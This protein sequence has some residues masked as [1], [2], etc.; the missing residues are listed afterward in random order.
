[1]PQWWYVLDANGDIPLDFIGK[2]ENLDK[3]WD[4]VC[5]KIGQEFGLPHKN[6]SLWADN[7]LKWTE[8]E[9]NA[10][11][12]VYKRDYDLFYPDIVGVF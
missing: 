3:D 1:M 12:G 11:K 6:P 9:E 4:K 5:K 2:Y 8:S 10:I 7:P